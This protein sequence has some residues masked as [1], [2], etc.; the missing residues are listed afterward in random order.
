MYLFSPDTRVH[1]IGSG[2]VGG[3][4]DVVRRAGINAQFDV[5]VRRETVLLISQIR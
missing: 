5:T 4:G 2:A 1:T 3:V